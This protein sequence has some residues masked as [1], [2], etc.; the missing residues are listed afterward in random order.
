MQYTFETKEGQMVF[1]NHNRL[2]TETDYCISGKTGS[3]S[4][5]HLIQLTDTGIV[6]GSGV[7]N[8]RDGINHGNLGVPVIA[9]GIRCV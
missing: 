9:I 1:S 2:L 8:H 4:Y 7:G 5:T 3:V 6:P